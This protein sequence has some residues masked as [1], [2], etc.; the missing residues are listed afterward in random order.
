MQLIK[1][2]FNFIFLFLNEIVQFSIKKLRISLL[3]IFGLWLNSL[4]LYD[5]TIVY[6]N[7]VLLLNQKSHVNTEYETL[8]ESDQNIIA[9]PN[10]VW[11]ADFTTNDFIEGKKLNIFI[12]L[13]T[14]TNKIVAYSCSTKII[15]AAT[16]LKVL[17][18]AINTRFYIYNF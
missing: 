8:F 6:K 13:D 9:K 1:F 3:L 15:I 11:A 16:V 10:V 7:A 17:S 2:I 14:H 12:C 5:S 4:Q 18:K